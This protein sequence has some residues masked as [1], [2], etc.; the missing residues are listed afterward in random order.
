MKKTLSVMIALLFLFLSACTNPT[1]LP[2]TSTTPE[3]QQRAISE[4]SSDYRSKKLS[5]DE[6]L[7]KAAEATFPNETVYSVNAEP[8]LDFK[9]LLDALAGKT[10]QEKLTLEDQTA[11]YQE[12]LAPDGGLI[13]QSQYQYHGINYGSSLYKLFESD[14]YLRL[15][16][17]VD[18]ESVSRHR[19]TTDRFPTNCDLPALQV[20]DAKQALVDVLSSMGL[21]TDFSHITAYALTK[22]SLQAVAEDR[23]REGLLDPIISYDVDGNQIVKDPTDWYKAFSSEDECFYLVGQTLAGDIPLYQSCNVQA[24]WGADGFLF[25]NIFGAYFPDEATKTP[26]NVIN[27]GQAVSVLSEYYDVRNFTTAEVVTMDFVYYPVRNEDA[28]RL[29]P[30]WHFLVLE[31]MQSEEDSEIIR[32]GEDLYFDATTGVQLLPEEA[33]AEESE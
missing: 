32:N 24:I 1:V 10:L 5:I 29:T 4:I 21:H 11:R 7:F 23:E 26:V 20:V 12:Y 3:A 18:S 6:A 19:Y 2:S 13:K 25:F 8:V 31:H 15:I 30:A 14:Y 16:T 9:P 22:E 17:E 27:A 28:I 33:A